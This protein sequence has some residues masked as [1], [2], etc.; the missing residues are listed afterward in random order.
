MTKYIAFLRGINVGNI[1]IKMT[2]LKAAFEDMGCQ[3][4]KTYLQTGNVVFNSTKKLNE[5]KP[6]LEQGLST[7]FNYKAYVLL[8]EYSELSSV[9]AGYPF[10]RDEAH[11]AYVVFV[12][13]NAAL[14]E[15]GNASN[16]L[17]SN[18]DLLKIGEGV[19]YWKVKVGSTLDTPF[20]K[21][22]A[23]AKY[24]CCTTVRNLNT[25]EKM[26]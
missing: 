10:D 8:Y 9:M 23:K 19:I 22:L 4:V 24:K 11:H 20:S 25:L 17:D 6:L 3:D 21:L 14:T 18:I 2:D 16:D 7:T 15:I 12:E 5:L 13:N 1:R 26:V